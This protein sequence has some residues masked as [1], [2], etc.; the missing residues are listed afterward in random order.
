[1]PEPISTSTATA[2]GAVGL[3]AL[4]IGWLGP[5]GAD[6]MMV[7]M[8]AMAGCVVAL[9][10]VR[11][12]SAVGAAKFIAAGVLLALVTAWALASLISSVYPTAQGPYLPS[13]VAFALGAA[14][15]RLPQIRNKVIRAAE[16]KIPGG[17]K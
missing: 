16:E 6:V 9:S 7:V 5:V 17:D 10:G 11:N 13:I 12:K 8:S 2:A 1:M 4:L 3:T 15:D 14:L